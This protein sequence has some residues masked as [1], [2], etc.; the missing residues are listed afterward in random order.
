MK[1]ES[2][3][4][5]ER[6]LKSG[7]RVLDVG[8]AVTVFHRSTHVIDILPLDQ[9]QRIWARRGGRVP[10]I[11]PENWI[12][13]DICGA[14]PFPFA[15]KYFD[16]AICSH[17]LEDV[18]DPL[19]VCAEMSRVAKAG[20]IETPSP[21]VELTRGMDPWGRSWVGHYHHRWIVSVENGTLVFLFKPHFIH[22]SRRFS[23]P[24]SYIARWRNSDRLYTSLF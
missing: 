10:S 22:G 11:A 4:E 23:F 20:Y 24:P 19:R 14:R 6:R 1:R 9:A 18:R 12:P 21:I 15:D 7:A 5:I 17:T 3:D 8:G 13:Q 2:A 16:F